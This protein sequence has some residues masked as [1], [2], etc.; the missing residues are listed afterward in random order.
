LNNATWINHSREGIPKQT[1]IAKMSD[2]DKQFEDERIMY[3]IREESILSTEKNG[4]PQKSNPK[5]RR[6]S[7]KAVQT[8]DS[9]PED[10]Q[11]EDDDEI[12]DEDENLESL[13]PGEPKFINE[14]DKP[15]RKEGEYAEKKGGRRKI[16]IE[17]IENKSRRH[18]TFSKRKAGLIKKVGEF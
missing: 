6:K 18:V 11:E 12:Y 3:P 15:A 9:D 13:S 14:S 4:K 8:P 10:S 16:N 7:Q 2:L 5:K 1:Y 17:F